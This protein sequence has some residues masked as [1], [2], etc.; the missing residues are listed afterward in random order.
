MGKENADHTGPLVD[1]DPCSRALAEWRRHQRRI[2]YWSADE[3][4]VSVTELW[5]QEDAKLEAKEEPRP[6]PTLRHTSSPISER[7]AYATQQASWES[8]LEGAWLIGMSNAF[9]K[10]IKSVDGKLRGRVLEC[11]SQLTRDPMNP[12]GDT[13][14]PLEGELKGW[15][16]YRLGDFRLIYRPDRAKKTVFLG[17]LLPRCEA[18]D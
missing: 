3:V 4:W 15:W 1:H 16:R 12:K 13:V 6:H 14:K 5:S 18:Y 17:G 8:A 11:L 10:S 9:M 7:I 2:D